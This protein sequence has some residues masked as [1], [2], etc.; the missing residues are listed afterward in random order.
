MPVMIPTGR[1]H[2]VT[3]AS[4]TLMFA[5]GQFVNGNTS[6]TFEKL[7]FLRSYSHLARF[8]ASRPKI[9]YIDRGAPKSVDNQISEMEN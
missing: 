6:E 8:V 2:S 3:L 5:E 9:E 1:L 7:G 4:V